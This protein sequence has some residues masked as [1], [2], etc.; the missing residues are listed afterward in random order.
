MLSI[1]ILFHKNY[2]KEQ[3][4]KAYHRTLSIKMVTVKICITPWIK[5]KQLLLWRKTIKQYSRT[6]RSDEERTDETACEHS[7]PS[8][9]VERTSRIIIKTTDITVLVIQKHVL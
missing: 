8:K 6:Q 7:G 3:Q 2:G 5:I 9:E 4:N 1:Y